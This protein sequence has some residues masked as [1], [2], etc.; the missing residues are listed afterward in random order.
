MPRLCRNP[1]A[2]SKTGSQRTHRR[3]VVECN[4]ALK[5]HPRA[6]RNCRLA[7]R[8]EGN[9]REAA[10]DQDGGKRN[11]GPRSNCNLG[12]PGALIECDRVAPDLD[13]RGRRRHLIR[14]P[15]SEFFR[16]LLGRICLHAFPVCHHAYPASMRPGRLPRSSPPRGAT[17]AS[18]RSVAAS[19]GT[20]FTQRAEKTRPFGATRPPQRLSSFSCRRPSARQ[21]ERP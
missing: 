15:G 8:S 17:I 2:D 5:A 11:R 19:Q 21:S 4:N 18:V 1:Q 9:T 20:F 6:R 3:R 14:R 7:V 12:H 13:G 16:S 10:A